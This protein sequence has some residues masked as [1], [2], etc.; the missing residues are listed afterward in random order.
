M[1]ACWNPS[2]Y[3]SP[4]VALAGPG[5]H[6]SRDFGHQGKRPTSDS[7]NSLLLQGLR[8]CPSLLTFARQTLIIPAVISL[9]LF[10]VT[11]YAIVP[12]WRRYRNRYGQYLPLET[13]SNQT[14]SLRARMQGAMTRFVLPSAWRARAPDRVVVAERG[15]FD[16]D[17]GEELGEV[18]EDAVRRV[19]D[20]R[21]DNDTIDST[22]RLSRESVY[23]RRF[24]RLPR[25]WGVS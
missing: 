2:S 5:H 19:L 21:R 17:E 12:V 10:L 24:C 9:L 23:S 20:R 22:T 3:P 25:L 8:A 14:L 6:G 18:D 13:I 15:S 1:Q 11:T 7:G 16:S 4:D